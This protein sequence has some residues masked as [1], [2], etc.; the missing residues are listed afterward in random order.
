M[1]LAFVFPGQ[2]SQSIGMMSSLA[3]LSR[4]FRQ[5]LPKRARCWDTIYGSA[6]RKVLRNF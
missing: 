4:A 3:Q 6:A 1:S 5:P 2:A